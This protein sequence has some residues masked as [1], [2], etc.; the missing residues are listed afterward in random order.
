MATFTT[1]LTRLL[2]IEIPLVLAPMGG[3]VTPAL[4]A[5]VSNAGG[6]GMLSVGWNTPDEI[7]EKIRATR[8]LTDRPFGVNLAMNLDQHERLRVC[9][10]E[11]VKIISF[12]WGDP[13]PYVDS[14]HQ[15]GGL[16]MQTVGSAEEAR[17][18]HALGVDMVVAQGWEAGGHVWGTVATFPLVPRV[19]DAVAPKPVVAAGGISDG[20]G[21]AAA[22]TLGAA[23]IWVG[24]R[25]L[26]STEVFAHA[27]Y[28]EHLIAATEADTVI[29]TIFDREWPDAPSRTLR[30]ETVEVWEA[31]GRPPR[32]QRP[33]EDEVIGAGRDGS[34]IYRYT[35]M[36][37]EI[38]ST[39]QLR[40][41]CMYAGQGVGLITKVQPA[42]EIVRE[43][44]ED[45][46]TIL[47]SGSRLILE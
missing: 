25:F 27:I 10:E 35:V 4:A 47:R 21:F 7:R 2:N 42:A 13:S 23:G 34:A 33:N 9:F 12:F 38:G 14:V 30:N 36:G 45:C 44:A 1:T 28:Q 24:T 8:S 17:R 26:A 20:R 3:I 32:G 5:A 6:L 16:V 11:A 46:A 22:L 29:G 37:P 41:M 43:M 31:A 39:G 19:A 40:E 18:V 15:N